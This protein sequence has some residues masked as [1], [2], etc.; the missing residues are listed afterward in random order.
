MINLREYFV[1]LLLIKLLICESL[2]L[3]LSKGTTN[4]YYYYYYYYYYCIM[5]IAKSELLL[6]SLWC[7]FCPKWGKKSCFYAAKQ[8]RSEWVHQQNWQIC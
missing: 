3:P 8:H 2:P 1:L 7:N 4:Y 6:L 5:V